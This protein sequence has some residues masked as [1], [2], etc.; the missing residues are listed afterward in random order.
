MK[1]LLYFLIAIG[2]L[3]AMYLLYLTAQFCDHPEKF[4]DKE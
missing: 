4:F 3:D 1:A 2:F